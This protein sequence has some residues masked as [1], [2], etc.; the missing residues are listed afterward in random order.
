MRP[1]CQ[2]VRSLLLLSNQLRPR[3]PIPS[4]SPRHRFLRGGPS[5]RALLGDFN[6]A[7]GPSRCN[8]GKRCFL[9]GPRP[10]AAKGSSAR[11]EQ[12][13]T[14]MPALSSPPL[15]RRCHGRCQL[16]PFRVAP[17]LSAVLLPQ[18][19]QSW[20]PPLADRRQPQPHPDSPCRP[21]CFLLARK[22]PPRASSAFA[23]APL[24]RPGSAARVLFLAAF[25]PRP[26]P[27][28][29]QRP[30]GAQVLDSSSMSV[31]RH[32]LQ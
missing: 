22:S 16:V 28:L 18:R 7:D 10:M 14:S 15:Y 20:S 2:R 26:L 5:Q 3:P 29:M 11:A 8:V 19:R 31:Q 27:T 17:F 9:A 6:C 32:S 13:S 4:P 24:L 25:G 23:C 30:V 21:P 12:A 1:R